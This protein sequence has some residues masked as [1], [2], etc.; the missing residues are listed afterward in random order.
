MAISSPGFG[1][2]SALLLKTKAQL[3]VK[4][5]KSFPKVLWIWDHIKFVETEG[6]SSAFKLGMDWRH[7]CRR[8]WIQNPNTG[9]LMPVFW[10]AEQLEL[11]VQ[12]QAYAHIPS[13]SREENWKLVCALGVEIPVCEGTR[14]T[15]CAAHPS[16]RLRKMRSA[17]SLRIGFP[18]C[19]GAELQCIRLD[20]ELGHKIRS[21]K[22]GWSFYPPFM[23]FATCISLQVSLIHSSL[24]LFRSN[25]GKAVWGFPAEEILFIALSFIIGKLLWKETCCLLSSLK[26]KKSSSCWFGKNICPLMRSLTCNCNLP[27]ILHVAWPPAERPQYRVSVVPVAYRTARGGCRSSRELPRLQQ[28]GRNRCYVGRISFSVPRDI[29]EANSTAFHPPARDFMTVGK[30]LSYL[31]SRCYRKCPF[32]RVCTGLSKWV[33]IPAS[34]WAKKTCQYLP[35]DVNIG[36][37]FL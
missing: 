33:S 28:R 20:G 17:S 16:P 23:T 29:W 8:S 27:P 37:G 5:A 21:Q 32:V 11:G 25:A 13:S 9:M 24:V 36:S 34:D 30:F 15:L 1:F 3:P 18:L 22:R 31:R 12:L 10:E 14:R 4:V 35:S 7:K 19:A 6:F 26:K 2:F